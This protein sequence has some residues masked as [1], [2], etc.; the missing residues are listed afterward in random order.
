M[1]SDIRKLQILN[2][3]IA[4]TIDALERRAAQWGTPLP[5]VFDRAVSPYV[6]AGYSSV[7]AT[8]W[9]YPASAQ[10]AQPFSTSHYG[11]YGMNPLT[12]MPALFNGVVP[13][14]FPQT[15]SHPAAA[16]AYMNGNGARYGFGG[17]Q[18]IW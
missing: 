6:T 9:A 11:A 10:Y 8:P 3:V 5:G 12:N 2:D 17:M 7:P 16:S 14:A 13:T 1:N 15:W 18:S 4:Q